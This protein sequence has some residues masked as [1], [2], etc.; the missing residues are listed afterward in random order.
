[1]ERRWRLV[2]VVLRGNRG[3]DEGAYNNGTFMSSS[4]SSSTS[5]SQ[6]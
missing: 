1:M 4:S 5:K 6:P 2:I 3:R